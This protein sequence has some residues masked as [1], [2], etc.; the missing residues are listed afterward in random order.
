[1]SEKGT[2]IALKEI[3]KSIEREEVSWGEIAFL[4]NHK[5]EVLEFG[6][7][8][9]AEWAGITEEEWNEAKIAS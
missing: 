3:K 7:M 2:K 8:G 1:M 5:Q 4:Q 9:L 6:D